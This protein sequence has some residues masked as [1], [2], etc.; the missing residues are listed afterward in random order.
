[1]PSNINRLREQFYLESD[2][3]CKWSYVGMEIGVGVCAVCGKNPLK[4]LFYL[5][6]QNGNYSIVGSECIQSL[7]EVDIMKIRADERKAKEELERQNAVVIGKYL[8]HL[9]LVEHPEVYC[10]KWVYGR[11]TPRNFGESIDFL[12]DELYQGR[13][14]YRGD[15]G[16][17]MK[18]HLETMGI[19][20]PD[21]KG[22]KNTLVSLGIKIDPVVFSTSQSVH[23]CYYCN[24]PTNDNCDKCGKYLCSNEN[25]ASRVHYDMDHGAEAYENSFEYNYVKSMES[26]ADDFE[27]QREEMF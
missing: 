5:Q 4:Y 27:F 20:V 10:E 12:T 14:M 11:T 23:K 17:A 22:M 3:S 7:N 19:V 6:H 13:N 16:K 21:L 25:C 15:F 1:M 24:T 2:G 9:V 26:R 18:K 8:T